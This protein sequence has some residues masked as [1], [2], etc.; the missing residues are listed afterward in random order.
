GNVLAHSPSD[1]DGVWP[2]VPIRELIE[3][4]QSRDLEKGIIIGV[5]NKRGV[6]SRG[7]TDGGTQ[8]RGLAQTY[9]AW[10]RATELHWPRTAA[11]LEDLAT[12]YE[13]E[14]VWHDEDAERNQ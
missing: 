1:S 10:S 5:C 13:R 11:L 4:T 7:M 2:A 8:E 14:A 12:S 9:R 3:F 6:T